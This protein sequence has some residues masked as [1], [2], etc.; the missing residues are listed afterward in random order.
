MASK[1]KQRQRKRTK[2]AP[3][4]GRS[5]QSQPAEA[6][7]AQLP[8]PSV[9]E[10]SRVTVVPVFPAGEAGTPAGSPGD[11]R[12]TFV[13]GIPGVSSVTDE[14]D[15][16]KVVRSGDSL[17]AGTGCRVQLVPAPTGPA[18]EFVISAN[19][20]GRLDRVEVTVQADD[21]FSAEREA[22]DRVMPQLSRMA[23][24]ADVAVEVKATVITELS[25]Q[26]TMMGA[27]LIGAVKPAPEF[28]GVSTPEQRPLLAAYREGLNC[29]APSYQALAFYKIIE[30]AETFWKKTSRQAARKGDPAPPDPLAGL[31]PA[32]LADLPEGPPWSKDRFAP[33]LGKNYGEVRDAFKDV[34]RNA[35][36]H[37][38]PGLELRVP[39][40]IED[41]EKCREAVPI[42]RYIARELILQQLHA[43]PS[44][45]TG[46][47]T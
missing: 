45:P 43:N 17:L 4:R 16:E 25:T 30:G 33:Y 19:R 6:A 2:Q 18:E 11:Y 23:V 8:R 29:N 20:H 36:A 44:P 21:R 27:D 5:P 41:V 34:I 31:M 7:R 12:V 3:N 26:I 1:S 15:P 10:Y 13:L 37:L 42:L 46:K 38:T 14:I 24:E 40:Y 9:T 22:H 39:D 32:S 47:A 28:S 35:V